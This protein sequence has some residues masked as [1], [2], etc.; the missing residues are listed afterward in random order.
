MNEYFP[1]PK[2]SEKNVKVEL[3]VWLCNKSIS[4]KKATGVDKSD[5][6]KKVDFVSLKSD[7]DE[8]D[9]D[10]LKTVPVDLCK[11]S[12]VV[13]NDVVKKSVY[14]KLVTKVNA[15]D[16][17]EFVLKPQYHTNKS[18]LE[19]MMM[20]ARKYLLLVDFI[21]SRLQCYNQRHWH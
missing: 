11:L 1:K 10:K 8:L 2:S 3:D 4:K 7:V 19:K 18:S 14:E 20:L 9:I 5:F 13:N 6:A 12:N 15:M 16:T 17:N 21:K